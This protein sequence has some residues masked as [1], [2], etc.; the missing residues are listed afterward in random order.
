M[1]LC[2]RA[3]LPDGWLHGQRHRFPGLRLLDRRELRWLTGPGPPSTTRR[4]CGVG[5][6]GWAALYVLAGVKLHQ[7]N[8]AN[9]GLV[10]LSA[11][12]TVLGGPEAANLTAGLQCQATPGRAGNCVS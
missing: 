12:R 2:R 11:F 1:V 7:M 5:F 10:A 8:T 4:A 3:C 6:L 9:W